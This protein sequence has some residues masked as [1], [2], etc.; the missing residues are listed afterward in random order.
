MRNS[1]GDVKFE[2]FGAAVEQIIANYVQ[3][4]QFKLLRKNVGADKDYG[5]LLPRDSRQ[6]SLPAEFVN[7]LCELKYVRHFYSDEERQA[8]RTRWLK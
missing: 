3:R 1:R 8:M 2:S 5:M 6:I 7:E 4:P